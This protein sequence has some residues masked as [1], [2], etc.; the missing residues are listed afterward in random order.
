MK[1]GLSE[2]ARTHA[3]QGIFAQ[4]IENELA[5]DCLWEVAGSGTGTL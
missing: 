5:L 1:D 2:H 3:I 4:F